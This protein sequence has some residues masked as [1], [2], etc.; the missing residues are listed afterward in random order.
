[1]SFESQEERE[2][3]IEQEMG[4]CLHPKGGKNKCLYCKCKPKNCN[5]SE[6]FY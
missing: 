6:G 5:F 1:M 3:Y 4:C 2:A